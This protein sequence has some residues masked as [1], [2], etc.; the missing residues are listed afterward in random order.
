MSS[1]PRLTVAVLTAVGVVLRLLVARQSMFADELSTHYVV[2]G[3]GLADTISIVHTDYEITPPLYFAAAWLTT[4]LGD[5]AELLRAPSLIAGAL[6]IPLVYMLGTRTVGRRAA[7]V[8]TAFTALSPFMIYYSAEA[9]GYALMMA[10]VLGSTL[11]ML[12]ALDDG[13]AR[14]WVLYAACSCGA[15]YTHYTS[16][17]AL[18]GQ[19]LWLLRCHP[20]ARRAALIA[21]V[22]AAVAFLPWL[23]GLRGDLTSTTTDILSALQPF[24]WSY[25]KTSLMHWVIGYP[26]ATPISRI[27]DLPGIPALLLIALALVL[28][29]VGHLRGL[30]GRL[31]LD[32]RVALVVVLALSVP[33]GGAIASAIGSNVLGTRNLAASWPALALCL[34]AFL[35]SAGRRLGTVAAALMIGA[36]ALASAKLFGD[37]FRRPDFNSAAAYIDRAAAPGDVVVDGANL[38][39]AGIP[40][41][42]DVTTDRPHPRVYLNVGRVQYNPFK[43]LTAAPPA[44]VTAR[45]AAKAADGKR[46]FVVL[47]AG[48]PSWPAVTR[49]LAPGYRPVDTHSYPGIVTL[50]VRVYEKT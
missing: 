6:A 50:V 20:E 39:P 9:R 12:T 16:V 15:V 2:T 49:A 18:L 42:L 45:Q 29:L 7:L 19:L 31:H 1:R 47:A 30:R 43:I 10:L 11:A 5:T 33:I 36:F 46:L 34:A 27:R 35:V 40:T 17:F 3:R 41:P 25:V 21:N 28:A 44:E 4:Q 48:S 26:Y 32:Q 22:G 8:A 24:T 38:S 13:R 14:W 37:D 23:S